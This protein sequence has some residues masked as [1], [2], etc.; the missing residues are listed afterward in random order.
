MKIQ[1][2]KSSD[3]KLRKSCEKVTDFENKKYYQNVIDQI[4]EESMK[5][6]CFAA[7]AVQFGINKSFIVMI[8]PTEKNVKNLDELKNVKDD[9]KI[10]TYFNPKIK[11]MKGLQYYYEACMSVGDVIGKVARPYYIM[12]DYQDINGEYHTKSVEGFEAIVVCH[13]IDHLYGIEFTD[14]ADNIIYN[15]DVEKRI[16]VRNKYPRVIVSKDGNFNQDN[17]NIKFRTRIY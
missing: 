2:L 14:K 16:E 6:F 5:Q 15:A 13:E 11:V 9:Y 17:I 12:F 3:P 8:S 4:V 10:T 7:A 1:L